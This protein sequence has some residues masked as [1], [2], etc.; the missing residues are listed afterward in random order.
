MQNMLL[1]SK[2][3]YVIVNVQSWSL[4]HGYAIPA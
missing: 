4:L 2:C 1:I 3:Q